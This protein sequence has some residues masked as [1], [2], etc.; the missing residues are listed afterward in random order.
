MH[1]NASVAVGPDN[2]TYADLCK[3]PYLAGYGAPSPSLST[4]FNTTCR[5]RPMY[6]WH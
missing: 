4:C 6:K 5:S 3:N 2:D 1:S